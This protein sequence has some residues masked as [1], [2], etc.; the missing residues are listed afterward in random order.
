MAVSERN[1]V[2]VC[3]WHNGHHMSIDCWCEPVEIR[4]MEN[5][6]GVR[7]L[8]VKHVDDTPQHRM[9]VLTA[10]ERNKSTPYAGNFVDLPINKGPD[11]P[12]ITRALTLAEPP[13]QLPPFGL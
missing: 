4:W 10:R 13:K 2:H 3:N 9:L 5:G 8:V 12:W 7:A 6:K 1:E 11:A